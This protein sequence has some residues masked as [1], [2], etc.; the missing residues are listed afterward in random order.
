M[1]LPTP[2][3]Q[4]EVME[5]GNLLV[6]ADNQ[7]RAWIK[8]EQDRGQSSDDIL[9]D[10][11]EGYWN[12][13]SYYPFDAGQANP[14]VGLTSAP[15][16]AEE[17]DIDDDGSRRIAGRLWW[18]PNYCVIDPVEELKRKGRVIFTFAPD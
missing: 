6:L 7:A 16:I 12:N 10:G 13:G 14:F 8:E 17:M 4:C 1:I 11:F 5:R 3:L 15:C 9:W 18:F 2:I